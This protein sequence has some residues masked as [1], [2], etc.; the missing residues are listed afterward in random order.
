MAPEL[1]GHGDDVDRARRRVDRANGVEDLLVGRV[2]E[3]AD[4]QSGFADDTDRIT[5]Q[6][7]RAEHRLLG[8]QVVRRDPPCRSLRT[9]RPLGS[10]DGKV[11]RASHGGTTLSAQRCAGE[12]AQP[13]VLSVDRLW[14]TGGDCGRDLRRAVVDGRCR[15]SAATTSSRIGKLTSLCSDAVT[16]CWPSVLMVSTSS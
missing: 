10:V 1:V 11:C 16:V 14:E 6:Q 8:L 9:S 15:Q 3:V 2:V 13:W 12:G 7:Q 5:R 4:L